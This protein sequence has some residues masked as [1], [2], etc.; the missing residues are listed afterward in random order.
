MFLEQKSV[1]IDEENRIIRIKASTGDF[2]REQDG[3]TSGRKEMDH[4]HGKTG[5]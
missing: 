1:I 2:D 4:I 5:S 3:G